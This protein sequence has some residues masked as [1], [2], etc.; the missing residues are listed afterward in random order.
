[1][2][3]FRALTETLLNDG[4]Q[5]TVIEKKMKKNDKRYQKSIKYT[6]SENKHK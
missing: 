5:E 3:T 1:M 2:I 6:I 4:N